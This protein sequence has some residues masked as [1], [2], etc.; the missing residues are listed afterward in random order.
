MSPVF[1]GVTVSNSTST[2]VSFTG[3][4]FKGTYAPIVWD[5]ENKSILFLGAANH[6]YWPQPDGSQNPSLGAFRAYFDLGT[7]NASEF[8]LNFGNDETTGVIR[9]LTP[10][11]MNVAHNNDDSWYDLQGRRVESSKIKIQSSKLK[12]GL[13]LVNGR[14]VIK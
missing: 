7:T 11:G 5:A 14:K 4:T 6:L 8:V 3:G 12:K 1:S 13:Y 10:E 2:E 9:V